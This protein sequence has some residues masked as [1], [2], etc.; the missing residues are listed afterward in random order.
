MYNYMWIHTRTHIYVHVHTY[1]CS[2]V[3]IV[4]TYQTVDYCTVLALTSSYRTKLEIRSSIVIFCLLHA[5]AHTQ[6]A[7]VRA[8]STFQCEIILDDDL[9]TQRRQQKLQCIYADSGDKYSSIFSVSK[10]GTG[11]ITVLIITIVISYH[12][13]HHRSNLNMELRI[14]KG[15][16][17][18]TRAFFLIE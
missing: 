18:G 5:H 14:Y 17:F 10:R 12:P 15:L 7:C 1:I 16:E 8:P 9:C 2:C 13:R 11:I 4:K 6:H 3:C